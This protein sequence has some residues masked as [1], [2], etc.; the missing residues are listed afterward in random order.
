VEDYSDAIEDAV[1][2]QLAA[3]QKPAIVTGNEVM[4]SDFGYSTISSIRG[5]LFGVSKLLSNN[6]QLLFKWAT[7]DPRFA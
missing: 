4:S 3:D 5:F 2:A 1:S 6:S 7:L